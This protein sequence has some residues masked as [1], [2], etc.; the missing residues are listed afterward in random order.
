MNYC[1]A[2]VCLNGGV[3]IEGPGA[4][5][6]CVCTRGFTGVLC[7]VD[8]DLCEPDYCHNN[9]TC[10][11]GIGSQI[12]CHCSHGYSGEQ[13]ELDDVFCSTA[14]SYQCQ[15]GGRCVEGVGPLT[16]CIC[17]E[18]FSGVDCTHN[19][20][21]NAVS[22]VCTALFGVSCPAAT[23]GG[24]ISIAMNIF[25]TVLLLICIILL[26]LTMYKY[27]QLKRR[28]KVATKSAVAGVMISNPMYC[29][30]LESKLLYC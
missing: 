28:H 25:F 6:S 13:C 16:H 5:T 26:L 8:P 20:S 29:S 23:T 4:E 7:E 27:R 19:S 2:S 1:E 17:L 12:S 18:G 9:G 21:R 10:I 22:D 24:V 11:E 14:P 30:N 15:N 3:C